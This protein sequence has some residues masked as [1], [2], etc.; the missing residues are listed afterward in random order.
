MINLLI[1]S[2]DRACQ[3]DLLLR[4]LPHNLFNVYTLYKSSSSEYQ[5]GYDKLIKLYPEYF[6]TKES[7]FELQ[8][9]FIIKCSGKYICLSTDDTVFYDCPK[10][11]ASGIEAAMSDDV[12]T[13]SFRYGKNTVLQNHNT[14]EMQPSLNIYEDCHDYIRWRFDQYYPLHNYGYPFGL[15][16]HVYKADI[17]TELINQFS[18]SNTNQLESNLFKYTN[19]VPK[20]ICSEHMSTAV[21]IP[22]NNMSGITIAGAM[23]PFSNETLNN[24]WLSGNQID[25]NSI[26][27]QKV[28]GC[29]QEFDFRF[30]KS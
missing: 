4:S 28:V 23:Y 10:I 12:I 5:L 11:S 8:T 22:A 13:F 26:L 21:N 24:V 1:W 7:D 16:M 29:H 20:V 18:F 30:E 3:L 15:D 17:L 19:V 2:K 14:G 6:F 27:G 25:I 9:R